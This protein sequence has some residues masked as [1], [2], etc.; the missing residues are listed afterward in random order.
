MTDSTAERYQAQLD[1]GG[2]QEPL[3]HPR[4]ASRHVRGDGQ[5]Q[6]VLEGIVKELKLSLCYHYLDER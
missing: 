6:N 4:C 3:H 1:T 2:A 5:P